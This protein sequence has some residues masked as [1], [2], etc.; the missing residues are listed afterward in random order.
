MR[1]GWSQI[2]KMKMS[3]SIQ[4]SIIQNFSLNGKSVRSVHVNDEECLISRNVYEAVGYD[5][6]SG[7]QAIQLIVPRK[8]RQRFGDL[9]V[10]ND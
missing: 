10:G 3:L 8:F 7:V 2:Y 5:E 4:R 9:L 1:A 6:Q